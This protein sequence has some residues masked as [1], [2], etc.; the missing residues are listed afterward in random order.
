[1]F[2]RLLSDFL[3]NLSEHL[4]TPCAQ[5]FYEDYIYRIEYLWDNIK[6]GINKTELYPIKWNSDL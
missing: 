1:M 3:A 4:F 5:Q 6:V 2:T